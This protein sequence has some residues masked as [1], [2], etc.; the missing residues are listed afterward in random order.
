MKLFIVLLFTASLVLAQKTQLNKFN[1][2]L[3]KNIDLVIK[4]NPELYDQ[5]EMGRAPASVDFQFGPK[6]FSSRKHFEYESMILNDSET[7]TIGGSSW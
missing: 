4:H 3:N 6:D 2:E 1:K 7:Q 5:N